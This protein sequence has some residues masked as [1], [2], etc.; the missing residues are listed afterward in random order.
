[1]RPATG[2]S[3]WTARRWIVSIVIFFALQVGLLF[4]VSEK[5]S[6]PKPVHRRTQVRLLTKP[7]TQT[8]RFSGLLATDPTAFVLAHPRGFSGGAWLENPAEKY[9]VPDWDE[10]PRWLEL[11]VPA[12][13]T[14]FTNFL[15]GVGEN[16]SHI[17]D[18]IAPE[19]F[20]LV[21]PARSPAASRFFLEGEL[22]DRPLLSTI[23]PPVWPSADVLRNST[24]QLLVDGAGNVVSA[25]LL[26]RSGSMAADQRAVSLARELNFRP[27]NSGAGSTNLMSGKITFQWET[28]P[29]PANA[30]SEFE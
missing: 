5:R 13:G 1:M 25:R 14:V 11:N 23:S 17:T 12:L 20:S 8:Q 2:A 30:A 28:V 26:S 3:R 24:V 4:I 16:G 21:E 15:R 27:L 6:A 19:M 22:V 10:P 18:K 7:M 9:V 29:A